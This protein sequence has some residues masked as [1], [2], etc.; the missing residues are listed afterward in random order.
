MRAN[1]DAAR[2]STVASIK[3]SDQRRN[4]DKI[5][6]PAPVVAV[7]ETMSTF[8]GNTIGANG[9][10]AAKTVTF[11]RSD[12]LDADHIPNLTAETND[13]FLGTLPNG[14]IVTLSTDPI[15]TGIL[16]IKKGQNDD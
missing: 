7:I 10:P 5:I 3:E 14:D 1:I 15:I 12:V 8:T 6:P 16:N 2:K 13:Q 4:W 11:R 9:K